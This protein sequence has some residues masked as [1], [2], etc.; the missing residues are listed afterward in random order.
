MSGSELIWYGL[1]FLAG[2]VLGASKW[3]YK[4]LEEGK[5]KR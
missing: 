1:T 4:G 2:Y 5:G 3:Y